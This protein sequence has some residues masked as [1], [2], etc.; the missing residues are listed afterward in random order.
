MWW[1]DMFIWY[2]EEM[3]GLCYVTVMIYDIGMMWIVTFKGMISLWYD[4]CATWMICDM[5]DM[6]MTNGHMYNCDMHLES[7]DKNFMIWWKMLVE[8]VIHDNE[9]GKMLGP[10]ALLCVYA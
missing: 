5:I 1:I 3:L 10:H 2:V 4:I 6:Q 7:Y 9:K 8:F